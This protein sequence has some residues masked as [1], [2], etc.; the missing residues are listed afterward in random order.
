[1]S[2]SSPPKAA[3]DDD[4]AARIDRLMDAI[5][6]VKDNRRDEARALLHDLIRED[7][8]F[9][10]AWLWM[11]VAVDSLDQASICLDNVLRINPR[12]TAAAS[13]LYRIRIPE[14]AMERRRTRLRMAR[15]L[16][17]SLLWFT[18]M[19]SLCGALASFGAAAGG[20]FPQP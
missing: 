18:I 20:L 6:L 2:A 5:D 8:D 19:A 1:M 16:S 7:P 9:Q 11:S 3:A 12:N 13:A 4:R 17:A 14:L 10:D 15:D